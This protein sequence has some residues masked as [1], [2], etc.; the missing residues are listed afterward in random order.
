MLYNLQPIPLSNGGPLLPGHTQWTGYPQHR[1]GRHQSRTCAG[2]LLLN[3]DVWIVISRAQSKIQSSLCMLDVVFFRME[4]LSC[5]AIHNGR[6]THSTEQ[7]GISPERAS[8]NFERGMGWSWKSSTVWEG[9]YSTCAGLLLLNID[10]WIVINNHT[11]LFL[12]RLF[13]YQIMHFSQAVFSCYTTSSMSLQQFEK[14]FTRLVQDFCY[15][16]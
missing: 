6:D 10:V 16:I 5:R 12:L 9:V 15:W 7:G 14:V 4:A 3:I 2:L 11:W 13:T 8:L 1:A